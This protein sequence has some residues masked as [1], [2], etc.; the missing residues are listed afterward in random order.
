MLVLLH[1]FP[2]GARMWEPQQAL[3][4]HGWH[5]VMPQFR[6]FDCNGPDGADAVSMGDYASDV[7]DL[8]DTLG[9]A[10][11]V[12][13]GISMGGY[14]ALELYRHAPE[15]FR[16]LILA[17]TRAEAD[18]A[19]ARANRTRLIALAASGGASA[20][21]DDLLPGLLGESTRTTQ[22]GVEGRVRALVLANQPSALQSALRAMMTRH[23]S[24]VLLPSIAVPTLVVVGE[25]DVLTPPALGAAMAAAIPNATLAR[26]P[27]AGHLASLEQP[28]AFNSA[29]L[30]FLGRL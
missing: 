19:E 21:A 1:A 5:L 26:L 24:T 14:V 25:E 18:S 22:A 8:L 9:I 3:A 16:G 2:L 4:D 28:Q 11:A 13:G 27:R 23:D 7:A 30:A 6:G 15:L 10:S 17:D 20:I 29:L 12:V